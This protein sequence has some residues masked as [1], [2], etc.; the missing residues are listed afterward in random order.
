MTQR[1]EAWPHDIDTP[2][3]HSFRKIP[4]PWDICAEPLK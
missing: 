2:S 3:T 1:N 4:T